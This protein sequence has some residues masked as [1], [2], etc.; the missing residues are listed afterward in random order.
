MKGIRLAGL[1]LSVVAAVVS[2]VAIVFSAIG[3]SR[4]RQC[5]HCNVGGRIK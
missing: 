5:K 3:M 4:A 1:I 2:V